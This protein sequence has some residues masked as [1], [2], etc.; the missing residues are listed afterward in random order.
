MSASSGIYGYEAPAPVSVYGRLAA[1]MGGVAL[2]SVIATN[3]LA[4]SWGPPSGA[5]LIV[6][7][8]GSRLLCGTMLV[9]CALSAWRMPRLRPASYA[10]MVVAV[11][12]A[13]SPIYHPYAFW[14]IG[15]RAARGE[16]PGADATRVLLAALVSGGSATAFTHQLLKLVRLRAGGVKGSTRWGGGEALKAAG[17][18]C[19]SASSTA[20]SCATTGPGTCSRSLRRAA[21]KGWDPLF[22]TCFTFRGV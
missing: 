4:I 8:A 16:L 12:L 13:L 5:R 21:A 18:G 22:R 11:L 9:A 1:A 10:G 7:A 2:A 15:A 3:I 20:S 17:E 6:P 19:C 14:R